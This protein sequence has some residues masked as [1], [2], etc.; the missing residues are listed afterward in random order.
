VIFADAKAAIVD[1]EAKDISHTIDGIKQI[2][3]L[4]SF[5]KKGMADCS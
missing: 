2:A 4:L 5:V 3:D 1:F